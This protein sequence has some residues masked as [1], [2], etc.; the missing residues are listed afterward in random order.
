[1]ACPG[2]M[3]AL[4]LALTL[5]LAQ[6]VSAQRNAQ[7]QEGLLGQLGFDSVSAAGM[8]MSQARHGSWRRRCLR[9]STYRSRRRRRHRF[10][11]QSYAAAQGACGYGD[12]PES[13]WPFGGIAAI[14]PADSPFAAGTTQQGCG[15]CLEVQCT[16]AATC[17]SNG[18]PLVVLVTDHC[19]G[20]GA[21]AVYLA[22]SAF[23]KAVPGT[24]LGQ[25]AGRFRRVRR[26]LQLPPPPPPPCRR[27][28]CYCCQ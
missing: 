24:Q 23:S 19:V 20:C 14:D 7:W 28:A 21:A 13:G 27:R 15:V 2:R 22:P 4:L 12:L 18:Q 1:M 8:C 9:R 25:V 5:A 6:L 26:P 17:G 11:V 10:S 16:D 3:I